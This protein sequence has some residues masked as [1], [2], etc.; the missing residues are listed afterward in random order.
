MDSCISGYLWSLKKIL[1]YFYYMPMIDNM[2]CVNL[3]LAAKYIW[4]LDF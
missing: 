1:A 2:L 4:L 3:S